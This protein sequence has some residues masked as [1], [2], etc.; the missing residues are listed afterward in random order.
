MRRRTRQP[1][2]RLELIDWLIEGHVRAAGGDRPDHYDA[3]I[4]FDEP[5][6][7]LAALWRV[8]RAELIAESQRRGIAQPW[9]LQFDRQG[10]PCGGEA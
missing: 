5:A 1:A 2:L 9:G 10:A 4:E 7:D 6:P 3:F 8:H